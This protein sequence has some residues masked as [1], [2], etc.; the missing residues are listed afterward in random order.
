MIFTEACHYGCDK[1]VKYLIEERNVDPNIND[2][3]GFIFA[4]RFLHY[5]VAKYLA[6]HGSNIRAKNCLALKVL[7]MDSNN[8][9]SKERK[10]LIEQFK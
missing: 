2:E 8:K 9:H 3:Y 10:W 6:L 1:A 7:Q 4:C 5:K